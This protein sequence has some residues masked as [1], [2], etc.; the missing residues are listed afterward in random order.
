M[1][2]GPTAVGSFQELARVRPMEVAVFHPLYDHLI[3]PSFLEGIERRPLAELRAMRAECEHVESVLSFSRRVL[4]GRLDIVGNEQARRQSGGAGTDLRELVDH[5]PEILAD[6]QNR[7]PARETRL[8]LTVP[9]ECVSDE[10]VEMLDNVA[11]PDTLTHLPKLSDYE[12][13]QLMER[14]GDL[15]R[16]LS[17]ARRGVFERIDAVQHEI[18]VRYKRGEANFEGLLN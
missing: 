11:G 10:L 16:Q 14:L 8:V 5:L 4:H 9:P 17:V 15:E 3:E 6:Q 13:E 7:A 1:S 12:V 2:D 18:T